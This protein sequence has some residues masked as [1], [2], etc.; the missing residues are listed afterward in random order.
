M[1]GS[2]CDGSVRSR[3]HRKTSSSVRRVAQLVAQLLAR[4]DDERL[5][6]IDRLRAGADRAA[7]RDQA[8]RGRLR[9]RRARAAGRGA[10]AAA[11]RA[12][13]GSASSSSDLAPLRRA[14]RLGRSTSTTHS[15]LRE[16]ERRQAGAEAA[17][18][19]DRPDPPA[20]RVPAREAQQPLVAERVGRDRRLSRATAPVPAD[21]RRGRVRVAVGVDADDVVCLL[22]KHAH[23]RPPARG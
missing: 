4:G 1:L 15:P 13:R 20:R 17:A 2:E 12:R 22:C 8:A 18:G 9:G 3:E 21:D 23:L 19:L 10:R 7:A 14:G 6:V 16:Q 11:P 5:E